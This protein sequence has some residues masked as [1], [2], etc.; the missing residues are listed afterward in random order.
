MATINLVMLGPLHGPHI[1]TNGCHVGRDGNLQSLRNGQGGG[2]LCLC[3]PSATE[4]EDSGSALS[5]SWEGGFEK[6]VVGVHQCLFIGGGA[7]GMAE[8]DRAHCK[9][10]Y[11]PSA[12]DLATANSTFWRPT[13]SRQ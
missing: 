3:T 12:S 9:S 6:V 4:V 5:V 1:N 7:I 2:L 8:Q 11:R 10:P 13:A